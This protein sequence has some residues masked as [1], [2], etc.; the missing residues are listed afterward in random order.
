MSLEALGIDA[1]TAAALLATL[2]RVAVLLVVGLVAARLLARA[3]WRAVRHAVPAE[4]AVLVRRVVFYG[5]S[6]LVVASALAELGVNLAWLAGGAGVLTV[7]LGFASQ[8]SA[9]NIISGLFLIAER[10]FG[11][12][13]WVRIG[14]SEGEVIG[15]DLLS[16]K[17]RTADNLFVRVPNESVMKGEIVNT[18]RFPIRRAD[19]SFDL[20]YGTDLERV[21]DLVRRLAE[22]HPDVLVEPAPVVRFTAFGASG[23]KVM[24]GF[25]LAREGF[26]DSRYELAHELAAALRAAGI[27]MPFPHRRVL[28]VREDA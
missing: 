10:P 12:G 28:L 27:E 24:V 25:W 18:T 26:H 8:T 14:G 7:A 6:A 15:I 16:V 5:V 17:L 3:A 2:G 20:P 13:D 1:A 4:R 23:L 11:V 19:L 9:S 22:D 21:R